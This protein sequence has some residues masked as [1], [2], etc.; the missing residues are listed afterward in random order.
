M[1]TPVFVCFLCY[2]WYGNSV[3]FLDLVELESLVA[4]YSTTIAKELL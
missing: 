4:L 3:A 2:N 1:Q